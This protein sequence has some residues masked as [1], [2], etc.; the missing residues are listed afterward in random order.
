M[1]FQR[2]VGVVVLLWLGLSNMAVAETSPAQAVQ[3]FVDAIRKGRFAEA[4]SYLLDHVDV[5]SSLFGNW[6]FNSGAAGSQAATADIFFSRKFADCLEIP[7]C[8]RRLWRD[9]GTTDAGNVR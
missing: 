9:P 4:Q 7:V 2:V 1:G 3:L 6:L 8:Q 5:S